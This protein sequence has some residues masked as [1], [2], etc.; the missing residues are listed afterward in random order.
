M[1]ITW[2]EVHSLDKFGGCVAGARPDQLWA[3]QQRSLPPA[4]APLPL[5][6]EIHTEIHVLLSSL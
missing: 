4:A 6:P 1:E 3:S 5:T 2:G